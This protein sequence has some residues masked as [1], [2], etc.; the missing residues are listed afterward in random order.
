MEAVKAVVA[1]VLFVLQAIGLGAPAPESDYEDEYRRAA[2][3][4]PEPMPPGTAFPQSMGGSIQPYNDHL[5]APGV[6]EQVVAFT[7]LCAWENEFVTALHAD[8]TAR[9]T[10]A[11][12]MVEKWPTLPYAR[13]SADESAGWREDVVS[14]ARAGDPSGMVS[15]LTSICV[16]APWVA[17]G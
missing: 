5:L 17:A 12:E 6:G 16:D 4:F 3:T 8:D 15:D 7:W 14:R 13:D 11:L 1:A 10:D 2:A 9:A